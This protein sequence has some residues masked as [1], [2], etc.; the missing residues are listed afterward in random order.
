MNAMPQIFIRVITTSFSA[1][2]ETE[3]T[4]AIRKYLNGAGIHDIVF[5]AFVPYWKFSE[6]GE[7]SCQVRTD[8]PLSKV[9]QLFADT[10]KGDTADS[11]WSTI[12]LP[13]TSFLWICV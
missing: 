4:N 1:S 5:S 2:T 3:V 9:Q 10:W 13:Q 6:H 12:H 7:L 11:R 8:L